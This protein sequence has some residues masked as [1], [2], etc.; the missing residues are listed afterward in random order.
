[1]QLSGYLTI[2]ARWWWTIL[3]AAWIAGL[4]A[5]VVGSDLPRTYEAKARLLVGPVTADIDTLRAS[6]GLIPTFVELATSGPT[7]DR[8]AQRVGEDPAIIG[9]SVTVTGN[10]TTRVIS[11]RALSHDPA[12]AAA[13]AEAIGQQL[14]GLPGSGT[15]LPEGQLTLIEPASA[16]AQPSAPDVP[17]LVTLAAVAAAVAA[18]VLILVLEYLTDT[19]R[20]P[21]EIAE[22]TG[23]PI[24]GRVGIPQR[25]HGAAPL[26]SE[27]APDSRSTAAL[28][29]AAVKTVYRAGGEAP[30]RLLVIGTD[31]GPAAGEIA[32]NMAA[33]LT[34]AGR[35]VAL[36]DA[37]EARA[38]ATA[39]L[40]LI[41]RPG[42]LELLAS[43]EDEAHR[44]MLDAATVRR[45]PGFDLVPRGSAP[46]RIAHVDVVG[47]LL[48]LVGA[49]ADLVIV[50]AA[51]L[52]SLGSTLV[53]AKAC[54]GVVLV[55]RRDGTRR[56]RVL[57]TVESLRLV[58]AKVIGSI[59]TS[60]TRSVSMPSRRLAPALPEPVFE[61]PAREA[62]AP[63]MS[64]TSQP[65]LA[66]PPR[67]TGATS[68]RS[69]PERKRP[70]R[71][72]KA[73]QA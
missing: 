51:P 54:D 21:G 31:D 55:L 73:R 35:K 47:R 68:Q 40:N 48:D 28:R 69:E 9:E 34:Q 12:E 2:I 20:D 46:R 16:P 36:V 59:I 3:V 50:T 70:R 39:L 30:R 57:Q 64:V 19:V 32:A 45:A 41:D 38:E 53:W 17:L 65:Q 10:D 6:A 15:V 13:I 52:H 25:R 62:L 18:L 56:E 26:F 8:V 23:A 37:D 63:V 27:A 33:I 67:E 61:L 66:A 11:V 44:A 49:R 22:L 71:S 14:L 72:S 42:V 29:S 5:F 7:L 1:M 24:L 4:V 58:G 43:R 60:R